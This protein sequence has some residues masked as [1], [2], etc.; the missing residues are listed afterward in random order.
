[1]ES[2]RLSGHPDPAASRSQFRLV[3]C[4]SSRP[5]SRPFRASRPKCPEEKPEVG[6]RPDQASD[7]VRDPSLAPARTRKDSLRLLARGR[8]QTD[9]K[10][11]APQRGPPQPQSRSFCL[12]KG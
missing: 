8:N 5:R 3:P 1:Q 9:S 12:E 7:G 11:I 2:A 6:D 10:G 4:D